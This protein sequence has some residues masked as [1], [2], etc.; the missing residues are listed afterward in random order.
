MNSTRT[1]EITVTPA[2]QTTIH[3]HGFTGPECRNASKFIEQ[4]LGQVIADVP[5]AE[6]HQ[7]A[8][9]GRIHQS[10]R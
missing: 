8:P 3:T 9:A 10:S 6:M 7:T 2:G 4:A 1:I 5:T